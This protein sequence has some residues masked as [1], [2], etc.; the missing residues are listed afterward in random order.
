MPSQ[1]DTARNGRRAR[2]VRIVL[3]AGMVAAP[4]ILATRLIRDSYNK[5]QEGFH[6]L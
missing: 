3:N 2:N 6:N 1:R 5:T 4:A